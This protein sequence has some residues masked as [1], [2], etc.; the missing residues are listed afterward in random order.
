M[1]TGKWK[2]KRAIAPQNFCLPAENSPFQNTIVGSIL[3]LQTCLLPRLNETSPVIGMAVILRFSRSLLV[4]QDARLLSRAFVMGD[5]LRQDLQ[6]KQD[7]EGFKK[8][9]VIG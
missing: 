3:S 6:D 1:E 8:F 5:G 9:P 7:S 2:L 4:R